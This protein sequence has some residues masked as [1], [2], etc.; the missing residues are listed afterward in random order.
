MPE[1]TGDTAPLDRWGKWIQGPTPINA[2][3]PTAEAEEIRVRV[4]D[5][6]IERGAQTERLSED[7]DLFRAL[8]AAAIL[9]PG[10][11]GEPLHP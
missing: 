3:F 8:T 2:E 5:L 1:M 7:S 11:R 6:L 10:W 9:G 4:A